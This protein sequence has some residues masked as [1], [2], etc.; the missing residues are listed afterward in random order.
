MPEIFTIK[1]SD[2]VLKV[3][4]NIDPARFDISKYEAFLD[5]LCGTREFQKEAIRTVLRYLLGGRYKNL[6]DLAEENY[7]QN[8]N[9]RELYPTFSDFERHLQL[10]DKLSCTIDLAT[11]TGKSYVLYGIARI[12]LAEGV[13]DRVLVLAPSTTIEKGLTEKFRQLSADADLLRLI[14]EDARIR[15]PRIINATETIGAGDICIE[16]I[17]AVYEYVKSSVQDSLTGRGQTTLVLNDEVHHAYNPPGRDQAIKKWK[18]FLLDEKYNFKYIVGATGTA[19]IGND[20]FT[21]VVYRYSLRQAI[22]ERTVKTIRYV[23]EDSP[24]GE[25]EKFQKI[26]DNHLENKMRYRK[27]KPLTIIVTKDISACKRLTEKWIN[28]IAEKENI[29]KSE[30]EKKV[31]IVTSSPEH[32]G[33]VLKLDRVDEKDN[34]VEWITSVCLQKVGM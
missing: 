7:N 3:S 14:P 18:E 28:F 16:N 22:E 32:K 10:P 6:R 26:Y 25:N 23:A 4:E 21:D 20:Y 30:A 12:M 2:L 29:P 1:A 5:A 31:L 33:N 15:N 9:L 11:G 13:V 8:P 27:I 17:H 19:Y 34:P 24:G